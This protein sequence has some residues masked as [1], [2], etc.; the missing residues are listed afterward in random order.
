M[1]TLLKIIEKVDIGIQRSSTVEVP[2]F[3]RKV[4]IILGIT[5]SMKIAKLN[6]FAKS[7]FQLRHSKE[8]LF[9]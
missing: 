4:R 7:G 8:F 2:C 3:F 5:V 6:V 9:F 1:H